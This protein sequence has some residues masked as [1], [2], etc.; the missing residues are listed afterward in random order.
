M[1]GDYKGDFEMVGTLVSGESV[2]N[3]RIGFRNFRNYEAHINSI[4]QGCN[5]EDSIF[6]G[7]I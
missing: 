6:N 3:T 1:L 2:R 4:D 5:P 7:Y